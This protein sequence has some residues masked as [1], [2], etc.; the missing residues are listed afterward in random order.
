MPLVKSHRAHVSPRF[1]QASGSCAD[2]S[3]IQ[4]LR[5][6]ETFFGTRFKIAQADQGA[7]V[8]C[9]GVGYS[10]VNKSVA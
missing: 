6:V 2:H 8:S 5:D 1:A 9:V 3:S 7:I 10:N 4:F